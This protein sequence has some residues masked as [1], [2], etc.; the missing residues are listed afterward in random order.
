MSVRGSATFSEEDIER[1][2]GGVCDQAGFLQQPTTDILRKRLLKTR[3]AIVS[4]TLH[5][6]TLG[7]YYKHKRIPRGLRTHLKPL[8]F[9]Y[10]KDFVRRFELISDR[11]SLDIMLLNMEFLQ[12]TLDQ[13]KLKSDALEQELKT[14]CSGE[15]FSTLIEQLE[16]NL[17]KFKLDI[18]NTK[19]AK[20]HR[21]QED[22]EKGAIYSW[23]QQSEVVQPARP[24]RRGR[25][26]LWRGAARGTDTDSSEDRPF[27]GEVME[28][29]GADTG[30]EAENITGA[31]NSRVTRSQ[32]ARG[33]VG[34]RGRGP[35]NR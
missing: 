24:Y 13:D 8:L 17:A 2:L 25:Q 21:D 22:Y 31:G 15:E 34:Q 1:I 23:H 9:P 6:A 19:R 33:Q 30:G 11:Y 7:E 27:L 29:S 32:R 35:R 18:E 12:G 14:K 16:N 5:A 28:Q 10:N 4:G 3:R 26:R 20:W